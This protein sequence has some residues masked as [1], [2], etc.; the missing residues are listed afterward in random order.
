MLSVT[1]KHLMLSAIML[2]VVMLSVTMLSVV[3]P[4]FVF[5]YSQITVVSNGKK[6]FTR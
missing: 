5:Y 1:Y 6:G 4:Q 3:A 2:K